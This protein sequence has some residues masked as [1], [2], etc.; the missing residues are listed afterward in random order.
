MEWRLQDSDYVSTFEFHEHRERANHLAQR[1]HNPR[2]RRTAR[3]IWDL[4][5]ISVV[6]LG[7]G[8]GGLL[9][10]LNGLPCWGYDFCPANI[11]GGKEREVDIEFIDVFNTRD[12]PRWAELVVMTEV[13]EHLAHPHD[14]V[15][16]VS[17][18]CEY[19]VAS[20]PH[21]EHP[22]CELGTDPCHI[23]AWD[24]E[25]YYE[26]VSEHFTILRHEVIDWSQII[27]GRSK[28]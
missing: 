9:K 12:V 8:D 5:P 20:S 18:N 24:M 4:N 22:G 7:C 26:M 28:K 11:E 1:E 25:G 6:D 27:V 13:L 23:W 3:L 21:G 14:I 16:W 2:L 17:E 10:L 19:L 15:E